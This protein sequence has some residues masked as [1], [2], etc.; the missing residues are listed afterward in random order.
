M[1]K[2]Q[3]LYFIF[4]SPSAEQLK[5]ARDSGAKIRNSEVAGASD[6]IEGC[7]AVMG[8]VPAAYE[9]IKRHSGDKKAQQLSG[10]S[11]PNTSAKSASKATTSSDDGVG[12]ST[13]SGGS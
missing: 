3:V 13:D 2:A 10:K 12:A 7:E 1:D 4:G 8:D 5:L 6:Y 9:G 11:A